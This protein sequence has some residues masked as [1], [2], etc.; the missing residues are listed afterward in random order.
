LGLREFTGIQNLR[1]AVIQLL[2]A[3]DDPPLVGG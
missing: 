3:F 2:A 1:E